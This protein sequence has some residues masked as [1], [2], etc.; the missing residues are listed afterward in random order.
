VALIGDASGSLDAVTGEGLCQAFR[1]AEALADA[2]ASGRLES[3]QAAHERIRRGPALMAE[4]LLLL[5]RRDTL[6]GRVLAALESRPA[7]FA[8]MI[9]SHVG[10]SRPLGMVWPLVSLGWSLLT[11]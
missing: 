8:S 3:Y 9:E 11:V 7:V 10:E 1:Q 4:L 6:R 5:D 2:L